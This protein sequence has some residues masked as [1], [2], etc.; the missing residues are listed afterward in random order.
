MASIAL[1]VRLPTPLNPE[2]PHLT[3]FQ[4]DEP[5]VWAGPMLLG[6]P[7]APTDTV[8]QLKR[9]VAGALCGS[10]ACSR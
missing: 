8:A 5:P 1:N 4:S 2:A 10:A 9:R 7:A 3:R 6:V